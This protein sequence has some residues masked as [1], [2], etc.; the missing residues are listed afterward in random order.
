MREEITAATCRSCGVCC[1]SLD[2][3]DCY[4]DV[5]VDDMERLG[6]AFVRRHVM[7]ARPF[8]L[9]ASAIDGGRFPPGVIKT[10][11][12]AQKTGP[13]KG[14]S[15]C[16][17]VALRGSLMHQTSCAVYAKRPEVCRKAVKPGDV[18]CRRVRRMFRDLIADL[19]QS[20]PTGSR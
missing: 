19:S 17:C 1:V 15:A 6:D 18:T 14:C 20:S 2:E 4:C 11:W 12:K 13:L 16:V 8:D 7:L 9:L 3:A 5:T 10:A